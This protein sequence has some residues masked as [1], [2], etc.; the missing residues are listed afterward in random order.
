MTAKTG[1]ISMLKKSS[2]RNNGLES[3]TTVVSS[4]RLVRIYMSQLI[5]FV[6]HNEEMNATV[7][8]LWYLC[9]RFESDI[10]KPVVIKCFRVIR[11]EAVRA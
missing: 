8:L 2:R 3:T 10:N 5:N 7:A 6:L 9:H 4:P 11:H 1:F